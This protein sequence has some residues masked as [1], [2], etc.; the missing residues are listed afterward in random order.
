LLRNIMA[1]SAIKDSE[2]KDST[3]KKDVWDIPKDA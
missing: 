3:I 1:D 2:I